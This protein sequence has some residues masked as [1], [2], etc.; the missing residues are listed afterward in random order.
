MIKLNRKLFYIPHRMFSADRLIEDLKKVSLIR[1]KHF[2]KQIDLNSISEPN[3]SFLM[4]K[5]GLSENEIK[6]S[7]NKSPKTFF[8]TVSNPESKRYTPLYIN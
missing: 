4:D 7:K 2:L 3:I 8:G 6:Q 5:I 1:D